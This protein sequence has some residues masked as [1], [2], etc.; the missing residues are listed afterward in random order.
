MYWLKV[1][2]AHFVRVFFNVLNNFTSEFRIRKNAKRN[3]LCLNA[4]ESI[5]VDVTSALCY[6][7]L[8]ARSC[9]YLIPCSGNLQTLYESGNKECNAA[10]NF[11]TF[12]RDM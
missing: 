2:K 5:Q 4:A 1:Q 3:L 9:S 7:L 6:V 8:Q 10:L 11:I 12:T